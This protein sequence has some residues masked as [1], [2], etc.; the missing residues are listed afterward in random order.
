MAGGQTG[1][2]IVG[3]VNVAFERP[4]GRMAA[5]G[6]NQS[7]VDAVLNQLRDLCVADL[8]QRPTAGGRLE[9]L[10]LRA[11]TETRMTGVTVAV[12]GRDLVGQRR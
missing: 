9:E 5:L 12:L 4:Q 8:V 2:V 1:N 6:G 10:S 11:V 3:G 7:D